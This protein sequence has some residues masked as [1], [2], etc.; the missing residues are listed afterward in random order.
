MNRNS[1]V[2]SR[3]LHVPNNGRRVGQ[4]YAPTRPK[5]REGIPL[6]VCIAAICRLD[7]AQL[8]FGASD[9]MITAGDI[10][11][12]RP[13]PKIY[14]L[15][16]S[17][18]ALQAGDS[19][20]QDDVCVQC[21]EQLATRGAVSVNDAVDEYCL[22]LSRHNAKQTE[23]LLLAPLGIGLVEFIQRQQE[24]PVSFTEQ[25]LHELYNGQPAVQTIIAGMDYRGAQ[26]Y[27]V[28]P[29]GR[30]SCNNSVG[31]SAIGRGQRHAQ[32]QFM[33]AQYSPSCEFDKA[34]LLVYTAKRHAEV[35]PGVGE[36]T[37]M[38]AI[39]TH[40]EI[41][42]PIANEI[43][44]SLRTAYDQMSKEQ[45]DATQR[46]EQTVAASIRAHLNRSVARP[47]P[48]SESAQP[49]DQPHPM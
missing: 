41:V 21:A 28:D 13:L 43:E 38:F 16:R 45:W 12:E 25:V 14:R 34:A 15:T 46:A 1:P 7:N 9:Q 27:V 10:K 19:A 47:L 18:V 3:Q 48:P 44:E 2:A 23:R 37:D 11:F 22:Q 36:R 30:A 26:L 39:L 20:V 4:G 8:I 29:D 6:T 24:F 31:F 49:A 32:S 40:G 5:E 33:F 42:F 35:S 17:I